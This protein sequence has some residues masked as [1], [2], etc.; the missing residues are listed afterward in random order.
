MHDPTCSTKG[1]VT[2][3]NVDN[4][5][6]FNTKDDLDPEET[7]AAVL[8]PCLFIALIITI[9]GSIWIY[10][11]MKKKE[12]GEEETDKPSEKP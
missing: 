12:K 2:N 5:N 6:Y 8:V 10:K 11:T 3:T 7:V 4:K 1:T 9:I